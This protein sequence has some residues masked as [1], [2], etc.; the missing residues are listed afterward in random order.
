MEPLVPAADGIPGM[1]GVAEPDP[2]AASEAPATA[3][4]VP[5]VVVEIGVVTIGSKALAGWN[6]TEV[7]ASA[8]RH[9]GTGCKPSRPEGFAS[10][11]CI[12][13]GYLCPQVF[14]DPCEMFPW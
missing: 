5:L 10:S 1:D 14:V 2:V 12:V 4:T 3:P 11:D 7:M 6:S 9:P 13:P 8:P